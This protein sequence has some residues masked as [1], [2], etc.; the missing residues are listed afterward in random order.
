[1]DDLI[2][3]NLHWLGTVIFN[4][5]P[6]Q[7]HYSSFDDLFAYGL[8]GLWNAASKYDEN[9][10]AFRSYAKFRVIGAIRDGIRESDRLSR[11]SRELLNTFY[12]AKDDLT[13]LD[14]SPKLSDVYNHLTS[15]YGWTDKHFLHFVNLYSTQR[16]E[17]LFYQYDD[18][19]ISDKTVSEEKEP[20]A[21][22]IYNEIRDDLTK[23]VVA[24]PEM[25]KLVIDLY[26]WEDMSLKEIGKV[27]DLSESRICQL[28]TKALKQLRTMVTDKSL[29]RSL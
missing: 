21:V 14:S 22:V 26:Y 25:E 28:H 7:M 9:R 19:K 3:S 5:F 6:A 27:F 12:K 13:I 11:N 29:L 20:I 1:M 8:V 15:N 18:G 10:G 17:E 24:L 16:L 2:R 4:H 23:A